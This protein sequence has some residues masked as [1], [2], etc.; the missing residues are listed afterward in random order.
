MDFTD[1]SPIK[2]GWISES[3]LLASTDVEKANVM[4]RRFLEMLQES[5]EFDLLIEIVLFS[6]YRR[7]P[8]IFRRG[9]SG[10]QSY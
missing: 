4:L 3:R 2:G 8:T 1:T 7:S 5:P 6:A 9:P 10:V